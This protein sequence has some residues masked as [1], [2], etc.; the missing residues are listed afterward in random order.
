MPQ[1]DSYPAS[2]Q[3]LK[4]NIQYTVTRLNGT[5]FDYDVEQRL[6]LY[7]GL[8]RFRRITQQ[9]L[10]YFQTF[11]SPR[12]YQRR[13]PKPST[14]KLARYWEEDEI[15]AER[16]KITWRQLSSQLRMFFDDYGTSAYLELESIRKMRNKLRGDQ[17]SAPHMHLRN[18]KEVY[19]ALLE[20]MRNKLAEVQLE[21][22]VPNTDSKTGTVP[23]LKA[24]LTLS[25]WSEGTIDI[26][27]IMY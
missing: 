4:M 26:P 19:S 27:L 11:Q 22:K 3:Y 20:A 8:H 13:D 5:G 1:I 7:P 16:K 14:D 6:H 23:C 10:E 2:I 21:E 15:L 17:R 18:M 12:Q 25:S 24:I 9:F